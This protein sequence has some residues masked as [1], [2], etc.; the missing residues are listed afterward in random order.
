MRLKIS[1]QFILDLSISGLFAL[2]SMTILTFIIPL[3]VTRS[4]LVG[5]SKAVAI[6]FVTLSILFL[7]SWFFNKDFKLK[8]KIDF[9]EFKDFFLL[10][11]PLSPVINYTLINTEYLT[12]SGL[13]YLF[14]TTFTFILFLSFILPIIFSYFASIN[15][16]IISGLSLSFTILSMPKIYFGNY[17]LGNLFFTQGLYLVISFTSLYLLYL[18]DKKLTYITVILFMIAGTVYNFSNYY[19]HNTSISKA[20]IKKSDKLLKFINNENNKII[21]KKNIYL[22]VYESYGN[23]ETI[24]YYGFDNSEQVEFLEKLGFKVY[25]GIYSNASASESSTA[26]ILDINGKLYPSHDGPKTSFYRPYLSGNTFA[27]DIFKYNG[28]KT[29]G[30]FPHSFFFQQPI[31]WDE[32]QPKEITG[33]LGGEILTKS[34]FE[35]FFRHDVFTDYFDYNNYLQFKKKYLTSNKKD[36]LFY[37][38]NKLPGHS[39]HSTRCNDD[40]KKIYFKGLRKANVEMKNDVLNVLKNDPNSIIVLVGDHGPY[41][42]KNC[43]GLQ[44]LYDTSV[45]N[46]YDLQDRYGTFLSIYWPKDIKGIDYNIQMSQDI[47]PAILSKITNNNN[48]FD[49]LK[50][51]RKFFWDWEVNWTVGGVNVNEG[52]IKGGIDSGK[53]LFDIRSYNLSN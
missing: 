46:K 12:S 4:F 16:L 39:G 30:L 27:T 24:D 35:G 45:I 41:L 13:L 9:P 44:D 28:Y 48:L 2:F 42:T 53:P 15:I 5:G 6:V 51:E 23:L 47:F 29:I 8:K 33:D 11:L 14:A 21:R 38:I 20:E 26:K 36:T 1:T 34:I 7:I 18:F 17:L 37:T 50:V 32:Y 49:E 43:S 3:G 19:L 10:A 52:V 22:L 31:G 25:H 40:D